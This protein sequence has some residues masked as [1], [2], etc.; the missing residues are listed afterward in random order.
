MAFTLPE[1]CGFGQWLVACNYFPSEFSKSQ[2]NSMDDM[3][4]GHLEVFLRDNSPKL[5]TSGILPLSRL[6]LPHC[7]EYYC[8]RRPYRAASWCGLFVP[9]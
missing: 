5:K 1:F 9:T 3:E 2:F 8:H 4:P 7:V 6:S